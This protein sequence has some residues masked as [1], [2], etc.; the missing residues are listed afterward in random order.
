M[1]L[2][3]AEKLAMKKTAVE[4]G[5]ALIEL[6]PRQILAAEYIAQGLMSNDEIAEQIGISLKLLERWKNNETFSRLVK[7]KHR[8]YDDNDPSTRTK[9][10]KGI[11][12]PILSELQQRSLNGDLKHLKVTTLARLATTIGNELRLDDD[13]SVTSK[14]GKVD[15]MPD[16][17][18][19]Q[20]RFR[21]LRKSKIKKVIRKAK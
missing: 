20:D 14:V 10:Y 13:E 19:L 18:E 12:K 3:R 15:L 2:T 21:K 1:G 16:L 8:S 5:V 7:T 11:L 6:E 4:D 17:N 9:A